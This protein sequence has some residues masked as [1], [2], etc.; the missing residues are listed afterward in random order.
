MPKNSLVLFALL[1]TATFL[2][3]DEDPLGP[4]G[5]GRMVLR[6]V[7]L[8][9][10]EPA[11]ASQSGGTESANPGRTESVTAK[12][13]DSLAVVDTG[14]TSDEVLAQVAAPQVPRRDILRVIIQGPTNFSQDYPPNADG[15]LDVTIP[16]LA[17]GSYTVQVWGMD[18][19]LG[20]QL[21]EDQ[22]T[23]ASI[24]FGSF[25]PDI[26]PTIQT[27]TS[28]FRF[29]IGYRRVPTATGYFTEVDTDPGFSAPNTFSHADTAVVLSVPALGTYYF[30]VRAENNMVSASEAKPS[31]PVT[32]DVVADLGGPTG[33]DAGSAMFLGTV[34]AAT[35]TYG[36]FNIYPATDEDWF[37]LDLTTDA[38]LSVEVLSVSLTQP[39]LELASP[40]GVASPSD[41]DPY[42]EIFD[43]GINLIAS[44]DDDV[45]EEPRITDLAISTDGTHYIRVTSWN[46]ASV[47]HYELNVTVNAPAVARVDVTP[48]TATIVPTGQVQ[49]TGRTFDQFDVELFDREAIWSS[50]DDVIATVDDTGLVTGQSLGTATITL[51]SEG[52]R[53][54]ATI[55]VTNIPAAKVVITPNSGLLQGIGQTVLWSAEAFDASDNP[56]PGKPINWWGLR[57]RTDVHRRGGGRGGG[58]CR[59]HRH[60]SQRHSGE[61]L[62]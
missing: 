45:T 26:D 4:E 61:L 53:G 15:S 31:D 50:S 25:L 41:L 46:Q 18:T 48:P 20:G 44:N 62:G 27:T 54:T 21:V 51:E 17:T 60:R 10:A 16:D 56:I 42:L 28:A 24:P 30:R 55:D 39:A 5:T 23:T 9:E 12:T 52:I 57:Q 36:D 40:E 6:I 29:E 32:F 33:D 13:G 47:G 14:S 49:L 34:N 43:P 8:E 3:C 38:T 11:K 2:A 22:T 1:S 7:P 19:D 37:A 58:L 35:G 59:H